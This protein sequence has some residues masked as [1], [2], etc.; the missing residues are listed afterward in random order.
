MQRAKLG[1]SE[2][3]VQ[4]EKKSS[5]LTNFLECE[6]FNELIKKR[7]STMFNTCLQSLST[8][9]DTYDEFEINIRNGYFGPMAMFWH[10]Y[11]DQW[12]C[13]GTAIWT[14]GN[15]LAQLFGPIAM[16]WH[17]YL[18]QWQCFGTAIWTNGNVLAQLFGPMVM[19]WHSYLDLVQV[20]SDFVKS[21]RLPG[22]NLHL[23]STERMLIWL[24]AY[25][26]INYARHFSYYWCS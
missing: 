23:Q 22:W 14:N 18:D 2:E 11:L 7:K 6:D 5:I 19:F 9:F 4:K 8:L 1:V 17:S 13:F 26:G 24:H 3:W 20:L 16:F 15:V 10:G 12:Q 21:V 25:D